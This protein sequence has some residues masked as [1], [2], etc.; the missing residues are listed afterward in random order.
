MYLRDLQLEPS[1]AAELPSTLPLQDLRKS[2]YAVAVAYLAQLPRRKVV[3]GDAAKINVLLG[4]RPPA[5]IFSHDEFGIYP[6]GVGWIWV[7]AFDF[8]GLCGLDAKAG[9]LMLL[10]AL[11]G[12]LLD[13]ARRTESDAQPFVEARQALLAHPFPLPELPWRDLEAHWGLLPKQKGAAKRKT[14]R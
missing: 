13:V 12:A 1:P 8:K 14:R 7:E 11:H 4:P 10:D 3:L 6:D 9:Q 2:M 5:G